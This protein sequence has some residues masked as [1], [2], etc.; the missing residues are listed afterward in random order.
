MY[1][2]DPDQNRISGNAKIRPGY[3][4]MYYTIK[5]EE[6]TFRTKET[7]YFIYNYVE[8]TGGNSYKVFELGSGMQRVRFTYR[9][10][11]E[12]IEEIGETW[13]VKG[14]FKKSLRFSSYGLTLFKKECLKLVNVI[15]KYTGLMPVLKPD[16][17]N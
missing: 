17:F 10:S 5:N 1:F 15:K 4:F 12:E 13:F 8:I 11:P 3:P 6:V 2:T 14:E 9:L 7:E 16:F